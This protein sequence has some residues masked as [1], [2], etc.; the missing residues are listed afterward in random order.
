MDMYLPDIP[1]MSSRPFGDENDYQAVADL[2]VAEARADGQDDAVVTA[3][4]VETTYR[5]TEHMDLS[6]DFRFVEVDGAAVAYV[7]TRWWDEVEGPRIYRH[8]C[9]VAPQW[10]GRGIGTAM[11]EWARG[12]LAERA[13]THHTDRPR[14]YRTDVDQQGADGAVLLEAAG[15]R[16][17]QHSAG[18]VRPNLDDIPQAP[19]PDGAEVRPVTE[20]QLRAIYEADMEASRDHWG[21]SEPTEKDW[22]AF[23]EFPYRDES[24]WKVAWHGNRV[25]GQVRSFINEVENRQNDR[26]RGWTEFISTARDWRGRGMATALICASMRELKA[27]GMEQAALG[28]HVEN[29]HGAYRLYQGLGFEVDSFGTIYE[30]PFD[31]PTQAV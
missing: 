6:R 27:R 19:L 23:L 31:P 10:R 13:E 29:P 14:V 1:G 21:F 4:D 30:K 26:K 17:I 15:Y 22:Q 16:A 8:M 28:V 18:L 2:V 3:E 25:I 12:H 24:L 7:T 5:N 11:L 9:K 20:D